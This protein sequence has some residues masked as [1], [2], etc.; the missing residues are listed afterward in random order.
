MVDFSPSRYNPGRIVLAVID[1]YGILSLNI[2]TYYKRLFDIPKYS[3]YFHIINDMAQSCWA[4]KSFRDEQGHASI[5]DAN[6]ARI[7]CVLQ[8]QIDTESI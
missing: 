2:I 4:V 8:G 3:E 5:S 7:V 1:Q 6:D